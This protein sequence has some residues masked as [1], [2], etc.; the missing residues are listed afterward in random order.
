MT[1]NV[2]RL[3]ALALAL[4]V[5]FLTW[6]TVAER[7]WSARTRR[8]DPRT[9]AL[10]AHERRLQH[11]S[12]VVARI[13]KRRWAVYRVQLRRRERQIAAAKQAEAAAARQAQLATSV[14]SVATSAPAVRIVSLTPVT[15]TRTS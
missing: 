10:A 14:T 3:Y 5:F 1:S 7:P 13:V 11:E 2:G 4:V 12:I 9:V 6:T 8:A 15:V